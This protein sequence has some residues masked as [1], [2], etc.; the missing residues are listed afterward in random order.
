LADWLPL[1]AIHHGEQKLVGLFPVYPGEG[2]VLAV[3]SRN[4]S[5]DLSENWG[6]SDLNAN[7]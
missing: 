3:V 1:P 2:N 6:T 7:D 5:L 4:P